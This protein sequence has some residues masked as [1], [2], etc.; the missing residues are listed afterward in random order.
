[1]SGCRVREFSFVLKGFGWPFCRQN[2]L[3]VLVGKVLYGS[4]RSIFLESRAR[5]YPAE[6]KGYAN[7]KCLASVPTMLGATLGVLVDGI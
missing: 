4:K 3:H 6:S 5:A 2:A 7:R 1:M